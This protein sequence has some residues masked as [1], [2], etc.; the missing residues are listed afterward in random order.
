MTGTPRTLD[1]ITVKK[2]DELIEAANYHLQ[3]LARERQVGTI[4]GSSVLNHA[5]KMTDGSAERLRAAVIAL[6]IPL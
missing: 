1:S 3:K 5:V 2:Y 6:G 4:P